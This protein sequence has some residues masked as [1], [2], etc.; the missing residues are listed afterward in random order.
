MRERD[1]ERDKR[2]RA[3]AAEREE[4]KRERERGGGDWTSPHF[5][6]SSEFSHFGF[7]VAGFGFWDNGAQGY[8]AH[9]KTPTP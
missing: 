8:L 1:G 5:A 3:H 7:R 6:R 9:K 4:R 2:E